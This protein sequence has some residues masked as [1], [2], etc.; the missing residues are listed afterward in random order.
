MYNIHYSVL[1]ELYE[2]FKIFEI[3]KSRKL[4]G[5]VEYPKEVERC[6]YLV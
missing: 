1:G 3:I 2:N 6:F 5:N 4:R